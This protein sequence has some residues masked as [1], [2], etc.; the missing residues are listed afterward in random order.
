M[1]ESM[2]YYIKSNYIQ[3]VWILKRCCRPVMLLLAYNLVDMFHWLMLVF[4]HHCSHVFSG[5]QCQQEQGGRQVAGSD[6]PHCV[7][8]Q[9]VSCAVSSRQAVHR[10]QVGNKLYH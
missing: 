7:L 10:A 5:E 8:L 3:S 4:I 6:V 9:D 1:H 2:L